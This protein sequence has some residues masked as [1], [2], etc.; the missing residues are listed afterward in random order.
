MQSPTARLAQS[1]ERKALNLVV[2]GSSPTVGAFAQ[3]RK[4]YARRVGFDLTKTPNGSVFGRSGFEFD[5][6]ARAWP[7]VC[8]AP[9]RLSFPFLVT[10]KFFTAP[11]GR[12]F[13]SPIGD[14]TRRRAASFFG[15]RWR[16]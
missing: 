5:A 10:T 12:C 16:N 9:L 6:Q 7:L 2:V 4:T 1:A 15:N 3:R 8:F 14:R 13:S 11:G